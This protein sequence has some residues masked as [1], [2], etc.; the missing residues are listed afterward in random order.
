LACGGGPFWASAASGSATTK[1]TIA[2][3]IRA[4]LMRYMITAGGT[5]APR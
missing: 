3:P 1:T 2:H 5:G 4:A